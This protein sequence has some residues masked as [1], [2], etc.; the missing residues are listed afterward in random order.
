MNVAISEER[1]LASLLTVAVVVAV[2]AGCG[3]GPRQPTLAES[4]A[5][6]E[7]VVGTLP[8]GL[9]VLHHEHQGAP[10]SGTWV[11]RGPGNWRPREA[12][13]KRDTTLPADTFMNLVAASTRGALDLGRPTASTCHYTEWQT[14]AANGKGRL[15][16]RIHQLATDQGEF[17]FIVAVSDPN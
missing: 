3:S 2:G 15:D 12:A 1:S 17:M 13:K 16:I 11:V 10:G 8:E 6:L 7:A 5:A 14:P 9:A 4:S